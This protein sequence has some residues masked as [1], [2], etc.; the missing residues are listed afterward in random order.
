MLDHPSTLHVSVHVHVCMD[1]V[2]MHTCACA[3]VCVCVCVC[4]C[5]SLTSNSVSFLEG[6]VEGEASADDSVLYSSELIDLMINSSAIFCSYVVCFLRGVGE[7]R[8]R[9]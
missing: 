6:E 5:T 3:C 2:C 4:V 1:G 9:E 7:R 8:S